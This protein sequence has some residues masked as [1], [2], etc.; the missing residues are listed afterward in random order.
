MTWR[1][2]IPFSARNLSPAGDP[3]ASLQT[4]MNRLFDD[5]AGSLP[6][7]MTT[8]PL[9]LDV[10]EDDKAFHITAEL[11]GMSEN[12]VEVTFHDD[13]LT[14]RG[15]KKVERD[16]KNEKWHIVERSS[17]TFSRQLSVPAKIDEANIEAKFEKGVLTVTLPKATEEQ[18]KVKKIDIKAV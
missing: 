14:I 3:F 18:A 5:M 13:L 15:E 12:E 10:K 7:A 1:M 2:M 4:Q 11:P 6:Q 9:R 8:A 16:E 17:G